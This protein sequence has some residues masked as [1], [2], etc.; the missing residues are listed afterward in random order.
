MP[1]VYSPDVLTRIINV[2]WGGLAVEFLAGENYLTG[3]LND[4]DLSMAVISLWFRVPSDAADGARALVDNDN[5]VDVL[6]GVVPLITWG[7]QPVAH[8]MSIDPVYQEAVN[9]GGFPIVTFTTGEG[10]DQWLNPSYIGVFVGSSEFPADPVLQV[11]IQT[12]DF[13][14]GANCASIVSEWTGTDTGATYDDPDNPDNPYIGAPIYVDIEFQ[15]TDITEEYFAQAPDAFGAVG[16]AAVPFD[17]WHHLLISWDLNGRK[18]WCAFDDVNQTGKDLPALNDPETMGQNDQMSE[19]EWANQDE[20]QSVTLEVTTLPINPVNLPG[21]GSVNYSTVPDFS[22]DSK[23]PIQHVELAE[24]QIFAGVTLDTSADSSRRAFIDADGKPVGPDGTKDDPRAPA[25]ILLGK[26]PDII[27]H[28]SSNWIAGLNTGAS[29]VDEDGNQIPL[30]QFEPIGGIEA[31]TP[32]PS[33]HG[34]SG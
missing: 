2:H 5:P 20:G 21:P 10:T 6:R 32:D 19:N 4:L 12:Q 13:A 25:E 14:T 3:S 11:R 26:K 29:G 31:Y 9:V 15:R 33:L 22:T 23:N 17:K 16:A 24:L 27:L 18:M 30:G 28:G 34:E 1:D 8:N 7:Q